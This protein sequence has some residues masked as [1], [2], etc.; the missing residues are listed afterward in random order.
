MPFSVAVLDETPYGKLTE[1]RATELCAATFSARGF[2]I[3]HVG[4]VSV[5]LVELSLIHELNLKY[6]KEDSSTDVL[7]FKIDGPHGEMVG[8]IVA[9][10]EYVR[11]DQAQV[12]EL[13]VHGA[14][15][16]AGMEHGEDFAK[17]EMAA[18]QEA[19][20]RSANVR[21]G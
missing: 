18:V 12:E 4:E 1:G 15:H 8:E 11:F 3:D 10:P 2:D 7:S 5:A 19:V 6:R 9:A 21:E 17:S 20:L 16:L 13:V 14:L